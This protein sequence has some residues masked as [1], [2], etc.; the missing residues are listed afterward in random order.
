LIDRSILISEEHC[1]ISNISNVVEDQIGGLDHE[2]IP[3]PGTPMNG[4]SPCDGGEKVNTMLKKL[5][6][7]GQDSPRRIRSIHKSIC[8]GDI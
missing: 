4:R 2:S 7:H 8:E 5:V 3:H 6:E 1:K